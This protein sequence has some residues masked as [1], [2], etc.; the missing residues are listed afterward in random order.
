MRA[1]WY[2]MEDGSVADPSLCKPDASGVLRHRDGRAVKMRTDLVDPV[3]CTKRI[4]LNQT[5]K[6]MKPA[7]WS[8]DQATCLVTVHD[9]NP[10]YVTRDMAAEPDDLAELRAE[11]QT[12]FGKKPFHGWDA[13]LLRE[14]IAAAD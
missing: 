2:V 4:D 8:A 3:P 12:K 1:T 13:A 11:Y 7:K 14:K 9:A 10:G 6:D 5:G